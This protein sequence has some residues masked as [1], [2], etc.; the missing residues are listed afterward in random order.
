[1][2]YERFLEIS[3][4][5]QGYSSIEKDGAGGNGDRQIPARLEFAC[6]KI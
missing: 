2:N 6:I 3:G 1:M 4:M 5:I